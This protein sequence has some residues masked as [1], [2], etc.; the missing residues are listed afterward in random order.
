MFDRRHTCCDGK[1]KTYNGKIRLAKE[2]WMVA[3]CVKM[4]N[5]NKNHDSFK[6]HR[7]IKKIAGPH[8]KGLQ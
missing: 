2:G 1:E 3:N 4:E 8:G 6:L 5:M 7:N